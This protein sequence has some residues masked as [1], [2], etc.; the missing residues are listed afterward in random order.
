[1]STLDRVANAAESP[2]TLP[3][4]RRLPPRDTIQERFEV[5]HAKHPEVY[6][7][8]VRLTRDVKRRGYSRYSMKAI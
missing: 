1:M 6:A 8:L 4:T 5:F 2:L 3:L 7:L